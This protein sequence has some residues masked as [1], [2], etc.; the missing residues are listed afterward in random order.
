[1]AELSS[2]ERSKLVAAPTGRRTRNVEPPTALSTSIRFTDTRLG[3]IHMGIH[4]WS[5]S[6]EPA[7]DTATL[8]PQTSSAG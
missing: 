6:G 7:H 4:A 5:G 1:M 8:L 3:L 2:V